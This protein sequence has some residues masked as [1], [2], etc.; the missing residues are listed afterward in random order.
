M[1]IVYKVRAK[2]AH[3]SH[4]NEINGLADFDAHHSLTSSPRFAGSCLIFETGLM[5]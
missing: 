4:L 3:L 5:R 2:D 1:N